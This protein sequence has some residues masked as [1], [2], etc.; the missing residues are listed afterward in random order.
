MWG[1]T[2]MLGREVRGTSTPGGPGALGLCCGEA[3]HLL[4]HQARLSRQLGPRLIP[5]P[6]DQRR[7]DRDRL[8]STP[9]PEN[10]PTFPGLGFADQL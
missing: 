6:L 1:K 4:R 5:S 8:Q 9:F 2:Q 3:R 7:A 10:S